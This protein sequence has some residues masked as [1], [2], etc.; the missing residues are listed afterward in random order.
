[1][2]IH[3]MTS[4]KIID[5]APHWSAIVEMYK[6]LKKRGIAKEMDDLSTFPRWN[7]KV[8]L[9]YS[10]VA[11]KYCLKLVSKHGRHVLRS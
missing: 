2:S 3:G 5:L 8:R 1:M 4:L 9:I 11:C 6:T 10:A 7:K